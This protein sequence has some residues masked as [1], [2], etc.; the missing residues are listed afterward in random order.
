M[1]LRRWNCGFESRREYGCLSLVSVVYCQVEVSASGSSLVH[2]SPAEC[3]ACRTECDR[4]PSITRMSSST[5]VCCAMEKS[6]HLCHF[7]H[8]KS[9]QTPME[10]RMLDCICLAVCGLPSCKRIFRF[11]MIGNF[12]ICKSVEATKKKFYRRWS[13]SAGFLVNI[14]QSCDGNLLHAKLI[15]MYKREKSR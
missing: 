7:M 1:G 4:E 10:S 3:D 12:I 11:Y 8:D 2:R 15:M 14:N 13:G 5:K 9:R 6:Y